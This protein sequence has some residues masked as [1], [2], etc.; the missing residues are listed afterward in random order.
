MRVVSGGMISVK[1]TTILVIRARR[2]IDNYLWN[3]EYEFQR[4]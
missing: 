2:I 1:Y 3:P 4:S